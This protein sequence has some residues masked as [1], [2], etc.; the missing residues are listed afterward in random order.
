M[1]HL[2]QTVRKSSLAALMLMAALLILSGC[3]TGRKAVT[4][5]GTSGTAAVMDK[6]QMAAAFDS[7]TAHYGEWASVR[8]PFSMKI[9][10]MRMSLSGNAYIVRDSLIYLSAKFLGMEVGVVA[11]TPDEVTVVDKYHR[12][13]LAEPTSTLTGIFPLTIA[14]I[15]DILL[16]HCFVPGDNA[17]EGG[18][19]LRARMTL[20]ADSAGWTASTG[21]MRGALRGLECTFDFSGTDNTLSAM[22]A[23]LDGRTITASYGEPEKVGGT[24]FASEVT[25]TV[26]TSSRKSYSGSLRWQLH[27]AQ[28]G[29][30]PPALRIPSDCRRVDASSLVKEIKSM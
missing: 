4:G 28:T 25:V 13:Y 19:N 6:R 18:K 14:N 26:P 17:S 12:I 9:D 8:V 30:L 21:S 22:H 27:R 23:T 2:I 10:G 1:T 29:A 7:A 16:G 24:C 20:Q 5:S 11:I 3:H 15:Q